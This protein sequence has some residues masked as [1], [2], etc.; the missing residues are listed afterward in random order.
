MKSCV[1]LSNGVSR[2]A[3]GRRPIP[4]PLWEAA[5]SLARTYGVFA[6][7]QP[8]RL[9]YARLKERSGIKPIETRGAMAF[10]FV[11]VALPDLGLSS[12]YTVKLENRSGSGMTVSPTFDT[13]KGL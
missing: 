5:V 1:D 4:E 8:L 10:P 3:S 2:A 13:G 11:E 6:V 9:D 7:A 12:G